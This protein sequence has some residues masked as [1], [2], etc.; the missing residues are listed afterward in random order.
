MCQ[1]E[2]LYSSAQDVRQDVDV[3]YDS[4]YVSLSVNYNFGNS[5][6]KAKSGKTGNAD[7]I[8]RTGN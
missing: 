6:L 2:S 3:Y 4:R 8:R 7:E 5:N 1:V